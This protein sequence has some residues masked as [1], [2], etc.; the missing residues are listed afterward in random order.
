MFGFRKTLDIVTLF[1]KASSPASVR[2][3]T[4][5]KQLSANATAG[6]T[7]HTKP[8]R[9]QFDLNITEDPPTED[10]VKTI[11]E[12]V[13][14][15]RI[16]QIVKGAHSEKD[17]LKKFKESSDN[18]VQ[19]VVVD[20]NNGKAIAGDN[21]SEILKL[22]KAQNRFH[23]FDEARL[24]ECLGLVEFIS[25]SALLKLP[26]L[27]HA[28]SDADLCS[29]LSISLSL[30]R[31]TLISSSN[32]DGENTGTAMAAAPYGAGCPPPVPNAPTF[33]RTLASDRPPN[34]QAV[35]TE[36]YPNGLPVVY[37][38]LQNPGPRG[39]QQTY[40]ENYLPIGFYTNPKVGSKA[41]FSTINGQREFRKMNHLLPQRRVHLWSRDEIQSVCNSIRKI[42]WEHMREMRQPQCWDDLWAYF[43]A[44][45][46][47]NYG[48][49]NLWNIVNTLFDENV[50]IFTDVA[51]ENALHIGRWAD[52]W[53]TKEGNKTKLMQWDSSQGP[54]LPLLV[55]ED[56]K[57]LGDVHDDTLPLISNALKHRR[58]L[59]LAPQKDSKEQKPTGLISSC[60]DNNLV[61][62]LTDQTVF[63]PSGLPSPP[64]TTS[65][66]CSPTSKNA[67]A[68]VI[69]Q[70]ENH[71]F[72]PQEPAKFQPQKANI[73]TEAVKALEQSVV[74]A[75][76]A[77]IPQTVGAVIANGASRPLP[78]SMSTNAD[79]YPFV[80]YASGNAKQK[81]NEKYGSP[82][83]KLS[84]TLPARP[85][86][87]GPR[88]SILPEPSNNVG[89]GSIDVPEEYDSLTPTKV[90][91]NNR[92][93]LRS[94]EEGAS[95]ITKSLPPSAII[96]F[97]QPA[98]NARATSDDCQLLNRVPTGLSIPISPTREAA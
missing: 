66:H 4:L 21:E 9:E 97:S 27:D 48:A 26:Q 32:T 72:L 41:V 38:M 58:A 28:L 73:S 82:A 51:K 63:S 93:T 19:P 85:P 16:P 64:Q 54:L 36:F 14:P 40:L 98:T 24:S 31:G 10:Q 29:S 84:L 89:P 92:T 95:T 37:K 81:N 78:L 60:A 50:I 5:L 76:A 88:A 59:L 42:F 7:D 43:D 1:H 80:A 71:Y 96:G 49:L 69:V 70:N 56:W 90:N 83:F 20:W 15:S 86:P 87:T 61:N 45:D 23:S 8:T 30:S 68:P 53:T 25:S 62:W 3:A 79:N 55:D 67:P 94:P 77:P 75:G 74:A 6:A 13:G 12:Y 35:F 57:S 33:P 17:A 91:R 2:V 11:L 65:H 47:Y 18:F 39:V 34:Q 22:L 52:A 44:S 46:L